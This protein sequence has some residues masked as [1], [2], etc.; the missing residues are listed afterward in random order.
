MNI[1]TELW[2]GITALTGAL[3]GGL[4]TMWATTR[5]H[6]LQRKAQN[7]IDESLLYNTANLI[8]VEISIAVEVY[9]EEYG[10]DLLDLPEGEPYINIFPIGDN[11]FPV[12]DSSP[13]SLSQLDPEL[14]GLIVRLYMRAKGIVK[15]IEINNAD[16]K[17]I[18]SIA[19]K[20]I[21]KQ[22]P[23]II[24]AQGSQS[25]QYLQDSFN[26]DVLARS[27]IRDMPSM[28][29]ALKSITLEILSLR[30][31]VKVRIEKIPNPKITT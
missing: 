3:V 15:M 4:F 28:A 11:P 5:S 26:K 2:S 25:S 29:T 20:D 6:K 13:S 8:Y 19:E 24:K 18:R 17:E 1:S 31:E 30:N 27:L 10:K 16:T 14:S 9:M 21:M 22:T 7:I 12:F 23:G